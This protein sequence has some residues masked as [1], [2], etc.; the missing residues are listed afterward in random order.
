MSDKK[1]Y[2][3][4]Q[5]EEHG[6]I[7]DSKWAFNP[8]SV[9]KPQRRK[10]KI[11]MQDLDSTQACNRFKWVGVPSYLPVWRIEQMLYM[12]GALMFYKLGNEFKLMPFVSNGDLNEYG[13]ATKI[14]PIT[15][16]G[17][18]QAI[19][20]PSYENVNTN[21]YVVDNYG[22]IDSDNKCVILY[23]RVNGFN[24][25]SGIMPKFTLQDTII[26]EII[27]RLSF[28]NI[29]LVNSQGKNIILVKEPKQKSAV[30]KALNNIYDSDKS[31]A[32]VKS[33]FDV[34]VI[35]N[36]IKYEEQSIWEDAMSWNNLR[37]AGLG[38]DNNGLFNKKERQLNAESSANSEQIEVVTDA[39]YEARKLFIKQVK[40]TFKNDEDF[41]RDFAGL[42]CIDLRVEKEEKQ[43]KE[44]RKD[45]G[46]DADGDD[47]MF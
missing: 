2:L 45:K 20:I 9:Y 17:T 27:T 1:C 19:K 42:D 44:E 38:I 36:E 29:N 39:F 11:F 34:Q 14:K 23:D 47:F 31:Y 37:L 30:E 3:K 46:E 6:V 35:N 13:L 25:T 5:L 24:N 8:V 7:L 22:D 21:E 33:M 10:L 12:R 40:E 4:N 16:N 32:I 15:Y 18:S 26:D 41:K 28:L 43:Q